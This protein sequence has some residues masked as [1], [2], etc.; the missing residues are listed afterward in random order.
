MAGIAVN[1]TERVLR[2]SGPSILH[3]KYWETSMGIDNFTGKKRKPG[4][5][6]R[7]QSSAGSHKTDA[8]DPHIGGRALDIILFATNQFEKEMAEKLIAIFLEL[9]PKMG[10]IDLIYNGAEWNRFGGKMVRGG[11]E[12]NRHV[13]HIHIEWGTNSVNTIGFEAVLTEKMKALKG[14][15]IV[16]PE[17]VITAD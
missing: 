12:I 14:N 3:S 10:W 8:A 5:L 9:R 1:I 13:S 6:P 15:E 2:D 16:L 4:F 11:D 17:T 7:L